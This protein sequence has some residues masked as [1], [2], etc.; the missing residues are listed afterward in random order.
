MQVL[1]M[2]FN[3]SFNEYAKHTIYAQNWKWK[4]TNHSKVDE[5]WI[6]LLKYG[7]SVR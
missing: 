6:I 4:P 3:I 2:S 5:F 7:K 1:F